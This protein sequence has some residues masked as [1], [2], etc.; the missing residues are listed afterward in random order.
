MINNTLLN[1]VF[2]NFEINYQYRMV[3]KLILFPFPLLRYKVEILTQKHKINTVQDNLKRRYSEMKMV[4]T[5]SIP[6]R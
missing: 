1:V 2:Y 4:E 3:S 6:R 5:L